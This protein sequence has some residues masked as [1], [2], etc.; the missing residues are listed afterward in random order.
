MKF[1][2][3]TI[4]ESRHLIAKPDTTDNLINNTKQK[5]VTFPS[6]LLEPRFGINHYPMIWKRTENKIQRFPCLDIS[7]ILVLNI[8]NLQV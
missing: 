7:T 2:A 4:L 5:L 8:T 6:H 3:V 1:I